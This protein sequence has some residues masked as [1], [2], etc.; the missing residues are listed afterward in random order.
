MVLHLALA[1]QS[2]FKIIIIQSIEN[3]DYIESNIKDHI[4]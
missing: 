3:I 1:S 2:I 4:N